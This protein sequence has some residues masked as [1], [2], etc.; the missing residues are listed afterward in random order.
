MAATTD[1]ARPH[2]RKKPPRRPG[3]PWIVGTAFIVMASA[4]LALTLQWQIPLMLWDHLDLVP[5][6]D[7]FVHDTLG[8][9]DFLRIHGGHL[10]SAAYAVLLL[11]TYASGGH[12]WLD[13]VFSWS[14]LVVYAGLIAGSVLAL[15]RETG[16]GI[17]WPLLLVFLALFPGHLANLQWG[18]Q[19]AVFLCLVGM[20]GVVRLLSAPNLSTLQMLLA[21]LCAMLA[22][23]SFAIGIAV[24]P[25]AVALVLLRHELSWTRRLLYAAPWLAAGAAYIALFERDTASAS[26]QWLEVCL[27]V[28]NFLGAGVARFATNLAPWLAAGAVVSGLWAIRLLHRRPAS[29]CWT[30]YFLVVLISAVLVAYGR[31]ASYGPD[32]AFVTRYVS[33]SSLFWIGWL[34]LMAQARVTGDLRPV[35]A[36]VLLSVI[37]AFTVFNGLHLSKKASLVSEHAREVAQEIRQSYPAVRTA[38]LREIYF[39]Q[40]DVAR[41]RLAL[42][43]A[44]K[45]APFD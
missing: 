6:Y 15:V 28:L 32:H 41:R 11:T 24:L 23:M 16:V 10:H 36:H 18:W 4:L 38:L 31:A 12:P 3:I 39:D 14:L 26:L 1:V 19:V 35:H 22:C 21:L 5:I 2:Q 43:H 25:A 40:P 7:G 34:G 33:F 13:C 30:G 9:S 8:W 44:W 42:L 29:L 45:F 27:Y 17:A 20:V 37:A